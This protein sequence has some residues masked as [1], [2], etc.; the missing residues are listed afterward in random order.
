MRSL[1]L[2]FF[3]ATVAS[4]RVQ[5]PSGVTPVDD[6]DAARLQ[7][8]LPRPRIK[9]AAGT[10]RR[11]HPP[12]FDQQ[13]PPPTN[14]E[15]YMFGRLTAK[16]LNAKCDRLSAPIT[17]RASRES[18]IEAKSRREI[19]R[20]VAKGKGREERERERGSRRIGI[21]IVEP[22]LKFVYGDRGIFVGSSSE[23][24]VETE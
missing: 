12:P 2:S 23:S 19:T 17:G 21:F 22:S 7:L 6:H 15:G 18:Q 1:S 10:Q 8:F 13:R 20:I 5:F 11:A 16:R 3:R 24:F 14:H 4:V 9:H